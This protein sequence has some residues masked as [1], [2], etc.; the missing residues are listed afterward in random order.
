M[1]RIGSLF[2]GIGGLDRGLERS[3]LA[4]GER[5]GNVLWR[6]ARRR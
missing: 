1:Y 4:Y 3:G 2:S 6:G 5:Y